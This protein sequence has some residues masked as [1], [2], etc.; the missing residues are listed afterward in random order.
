MQQSVI[1]ES[2]ADR[3]DGLAGACSL[4][5]RTFLAAPDE[6]LVARLAEPGTLGQWPMVRDPLTLQGIASLTVG[7]ATPLDDLV[8]DYT[9][10]FIVPPLPAV[11]WESVYRSRER[12]VF[13][14]ETFDVRRA[15]AAFGLRAPMLNREPDDH[16]GLELSFVAHLAVAALDAVELGDGEKAQRALVAQQDFLRDHLLTWA[17]QF[18]ACVR[19]NAATGFYRGVADL[20]E[21]TLWQ[22]AELFEA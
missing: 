13:E 9:A 8:R 15:Y 7:V 16:I 21:A 10:L 2:V 1:A 4:L 22:A 20:C 12:L 17:P 6:A 5:A 3:L 11:P 14:K 19:E 18:T